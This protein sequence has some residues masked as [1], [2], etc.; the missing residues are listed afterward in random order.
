MSA[1]TVSH[2]YRPSTARLIALD[3]FVP[4]PRGAVAAPPVMQSWPVKDPADA[5]DYVVDVAAAVTGDDGDAIANVAVTTAPN[6]TGDLAL[7]STAAD[8]TQVVLWLGAGNSGTVY[9][10]ALAITLASGRVIS[11]SIALP[12]YSLSG[13]SP[14]SVILVTD[15][16]QEVTDQG[17]NPIVIGN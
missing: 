3:G 15:T 16:G 17:G 6:A 7:I 4:V 14:T 12:V 5:L 2:V 9:T 1:T 11:R 10:V 13:R 8:G